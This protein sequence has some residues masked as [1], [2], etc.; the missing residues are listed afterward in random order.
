METSHQQ[1]QG[2]Q[3]VLSRSSAA[4][5]LLSRISW[6]L[7]SMDMKWMNECMVAFG[8]NSIIIISYKNVLIRVELNLVSDL[9]FGLGDLS[10][11]LAF[12]HSRQ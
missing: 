4:L 12:D 2:K 9:F 11:F 7:R 10:S 8:A 1:G 3:L 6:P 5:A